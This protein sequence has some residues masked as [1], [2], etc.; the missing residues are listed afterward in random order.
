MLFDQELRQLKISEYYI[1]DNYEYIIYIY[2]Y[3]YF[4]FPKVFPGRG[5]FSGSIF[6]GVVA[7]L[8]ACVC[9]WCSNFLLLEL[10]IVTTKVLRM[11]HQNVFNVSSTVNV[12]ENCLKET[13]STTVCGESLCE[14]SSLCR[15]QRKHVISAVLCHCA[16]L[17]K[18]PKVWSKCILQCHNFGDAWIYLACNGDKFKKQQRPGGGLN[19][20]K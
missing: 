13:V 1:Y 8:F 5:S 2:L 15:R 17:Y 9:M 10:M 11:T 7:V 6:W 4:G 3:I 18:S 20:C 16:Y 14:R 12:N 19:G